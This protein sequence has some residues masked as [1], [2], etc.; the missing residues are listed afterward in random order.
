MERTREEMLVEA[1][2]W[3]SAASDFQEG[4]QAREGWLKLCA[5]LLAEAQ[6]QADNTGSPKLPPCDDVIASVG[7]RFANEGI[8]DIGSAT[9]AVVYA[10][11]FIERQLRADA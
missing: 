11:E 3:C 8:V 10:Y 7:Q 5:P 2:Q 4:G 1:L 6:P 9:K